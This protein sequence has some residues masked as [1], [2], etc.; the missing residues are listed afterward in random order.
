[1][2]RN[3]SI[4]LFSYTFLVEIQ[5][6]ATIF[7]SSLALSYEGAHSYA[8]WPNN[9]TIR[10]VHKKTHIYTSTLKQQCSNSII[11]INK[12]DTNALWQDIGHRNCGTDTQRQ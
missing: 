2:W 11:Y 12:Y 9:F 1:M 8:L 6:G 10:C 3:M 5:I 4:I 7:A